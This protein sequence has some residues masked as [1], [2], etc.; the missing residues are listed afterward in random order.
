MGRPSAAP[1]QRQRDRR[2]AGHVERCGERHERRAAHHAAQRILRRR[3]HLT[4]LHRRLGHRRREQQVKAVR[5]PAAPRA[6]CSFAATRLAAMYSAADTPRPISARRP[7]VRFDV[8]AADGAASRRRPVIQIVP[9]SSWSPRRR[10]AAG[11]PCSSNAVGCDSSTRWPSDSSSRA[12]SVG[13]GDA[14]G[15]HR[16]VPPRARVIRPMRSRPG[17]RRPRQ[18]TAAPGAARRTDRRAS[19]RARRRASPPSRAPSASPRAR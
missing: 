16:H 10:R 6:A 14:V 15:M 17:A 3:R 18:R 19:G 7:G 13:R 8:V 4:E 12:A 9:A 1:V 11:T 5:P 2:L